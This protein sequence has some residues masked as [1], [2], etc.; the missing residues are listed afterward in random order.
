MQPETAN[1]GGLDLTLPSEFK[2]SLQKFIVD[3][4]LAPTNKEFQKTIDHLCTV[5][6]RVSHRKIVALFYRNEVYRATDFVPSGALAAPDKAIVPYLDE[7]IELRKGVMPNERAI[8][9]NHLKNVLNFSR[10]PNDLLVLMPEN[11]HKIFY[12]I[13][14]DYLKDS[15]PTVTKEEF[16]ARYPHA[17]EDE[18]V[19]KQRMMLNLVFN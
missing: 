4:L 16:Y 15:S 12:A 1:K 18:A 6:S 19:F 10:T 7:A 2:A 9:C 8:M 3:E 11:T 5:Q 13:I 14:K 17:K